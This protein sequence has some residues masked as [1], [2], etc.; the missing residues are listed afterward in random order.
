MLFEGPPFRLLLLDHAEVV[1]FQVFVGDMLP[2]YPTLNRL[3][4]DVAKGQFGRQ[5][6]DFIGI[7]RAVI[8]AAG[9]YFHGM[10][11]RPS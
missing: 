9:D 1:S 10:G 4:W 8:F 3:P 11:S 6:T 7:M 2:G 5:C